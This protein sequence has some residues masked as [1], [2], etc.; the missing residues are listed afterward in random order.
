MG[1]GDMDFIDKKIELVG[2][3]KVAALLERD[4]VD[5]GSYHHQTLDRTGDGLMVAAYAHDNSIEAIEHR[6][7]SWVVGLQWHP[8][9]ASANASH[10]RLLF[11]AVIRH[12]QQQ[13][14]EALVLQQ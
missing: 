9:E 4:T 13:K 14:D 1:N 8:E 12:A 7:K 6:D 3:T 11:Q 2:S 10:R 5:A